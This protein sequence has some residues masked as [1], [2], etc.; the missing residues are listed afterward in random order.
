MERQDSGIVPYGDIPEIAAEINKA[1]DKLQMLL[2]NNRG[3]QFLVVHHSGSIVT[4]GPT[5]PKEPNAE[6]ATSKDMDMFMAAAMDATTA[7]EASATLRPAK[8]VNLKWL[9]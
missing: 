4:Q 5:Q 3:K 9:Q 6:I 1:F 8:Q 7:A 2:T